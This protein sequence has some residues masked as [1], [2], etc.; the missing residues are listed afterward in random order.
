M[1]KVSLAYIVFVLLEFLGLDYEEDQIPD[2]VLKLH[3]KPS[4]KP[5]RRWLVKF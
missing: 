4:L 2:F 3:R 1:V 5:K